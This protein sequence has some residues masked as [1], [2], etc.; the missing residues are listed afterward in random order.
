MLKRYVH[1][2]R[3]APLFIAVRCVYLNGKRRFFCQLE[4]QAVVFFF[5]LNE[6][7]QDFHHLLSQRFVVGFAG[8]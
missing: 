7:R 6:E 2:A 5:R 4:L 1:A 3:R 8:I